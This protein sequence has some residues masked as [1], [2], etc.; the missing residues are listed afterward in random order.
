MS[1]Q[2]RFPTDSI[3]PE[4][5]DA[6]TEE[7]LREIIDLVRDSSF[8]DD[9]SGQSIEERLT[10]V[11]EGEPPE[12]SAFQTKDATCYVNCVGTMT[13][14]GEQLEIILQFELSDN[15]ESFLFSGMLIDGVEQ[16]EGLI[17]QFEEQFS[18]LDFFDGDDDDLDPFFGAGLIGED[19]YD[20]DDEDDD[21]I[22]DWGDDAAERFWFD[23]DNDDW[24][25]YDDEDDDG[26]NC[27]HDDCGCGHHHH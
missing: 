18:T 15:L 24:D 23:P 5:E 8:I 11:F 16:P 19:D 27:G 25:D 12:W 17:L 10:T 7:E 9:L 2:F 26:C 14:K 1:T 4:S 3:S 22:G 21:V 6:F 13:E 20:Y